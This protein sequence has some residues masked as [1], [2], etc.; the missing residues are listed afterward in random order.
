MVI[1]MIVIDFAVVVVRNLKNDVMDAK[2]YVEQK[3]YR[4]KDGGMN[5]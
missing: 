1:I 4:Q 2:L 5:R 3:K